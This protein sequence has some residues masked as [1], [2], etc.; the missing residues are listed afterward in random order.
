MCKTFVQNLIKT[1]DMKNFFLLGLVVLL[2][3]PAA[4]QS[5]L[6][7]DRVPGFSAEA[8]RRQLDAG[9]VTRANCGPDTL[10]YA[11]AKATGL[12]GLNVNTATSAG[13]IGQWFDATPP[14][15]VTISGFSFYGRSSSA[16]GVTVSA[17]CAVYSA[18][19]DSLPAAGPPLASTTIVLDTNFYG[20]SLALLKKHATFTNPITV[21]TPF[22]LVVENPSA[23]GMTFI[24]NSYNADNGQGEWLGMASIAGNW[25]HGYEL[26][27]GAVDFNADALIEPH[28]TYSMAVAFTQDQNCI[29]HDQP[30]TFTN[31]SDPI[32]TSRFFNLSSF[33][34]HFGFAPKDSTFKWE[35]APGVPGEFEINGDYTY[36][37]LNTSHDV[38]LYALMLGYSTICVDSAAALA[39]PVGQVPTGDFAFQQT[40]NQGV[41]FTDQSAN[42]D[43]VLWDFG[44]SNI[45]TDLNPTHTYAN[46]GAYTVTHYAFSCAGTDTTI[47]EIGVN[48]TGLADRFAGVAS[49][50]P[51]PSQ[52]QFVLDLELEQAQAVQVRVYSAT[53]Q[54]VAELRPGTLRQAQVAIDLTGREAG[55][56]LVQVQAG[57]SQWV[58]RVVLQ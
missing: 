58:S 53:G 48:T 34:R 26:S 20:G 39:I 55:V 2:C 12:A 56:Y 3:L 7:D 50:Y 38:R 8:F 24:T 22:V 18:G 23:T 43:N 51:N 37:G 42:A 47:K 14:N 21:T 19:A 28:V 57:E 10:Q 5:L 30:A 44:D 54:R 36:T 11:L 17:V 45:S 6:T 46:G 16:T 27:L 9:R 1:Y 32:V 25:L 4:A 40:G 52:G 31:T 29:V 41:S 15:P 13:Q 35:Y 49:L 33:D